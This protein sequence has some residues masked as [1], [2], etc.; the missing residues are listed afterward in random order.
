MAK[1]LVLSGLDRDHIVFKHF[2]GDRYRNVTIGVKLD[3]ELAEQLIAEDWPVKTYIP[4]DENYDPFQWLQITFKFDPYPPTV[5][6]MEEDRGVQ[7][8]KDTIKLLQSARFDSIDMQL[9][10]PARIKDDGSG[11]AKTIYCRELL[12]HLT[13]ISSIFDK[14]PAALNVIRSEE[15]VPFE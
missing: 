13:H 1:N 2:D 4:K 7:Y 3:P 14:F 15:E 10:W 6:A 9:S 8:D 5:V 12:M 11:Y